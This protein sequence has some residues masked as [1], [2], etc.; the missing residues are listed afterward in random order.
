M[1]KH[2]RNT[3]PDMIRITLYLSRVIAVSAFMLSLSANQIHQKQA[4][5]T[6][7]VDAGHGGNAVGARGLFSN[8]ADIALSIAL[9]L[10]K[11]IET[12]MPD[13]KVVYTRTTKEQPG[14]A[15]TASA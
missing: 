1:I 13:I 2:L 11:R 3:S 6:I 10:G 4:I 8:E 5:T 15:K 12:E 9:K 14:G 7:V